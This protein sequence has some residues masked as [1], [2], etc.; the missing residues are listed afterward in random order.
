MVIT[1]ALPSC[2]AQSAGGVQV[3]SASPGDTINFH[4]TGTPGASVTLDITTSIAVGVENSSGQSL[5]SLSLTGFHVPSGSN[6]FSITANPVST[7]TIWGSYDGIGLSHNIAVANGSG[8]FSI[9]NV[10]GL[11][12]DIGVKGKANGPNVNMDI[13]ASTGVSV[14]NSGNYTATVNTK[15]LPAG[16]YDV[17]QDNV[18]IAIVYLGVQAPTLPTPP[19]TPTLPAQVNSTAQPVNGTSNGSSINTE[20]LVAML[21]TLGICC[22]GGYLLILKKK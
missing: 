7:M 20:D 22:T 9:S 8:S 17:Y 3:I 11:T 5:Y 21:A 6:R 14:D 13:S 18:L 15:G 1:V 2:N 19:Q 10:P 16:I 12:Y 4:G